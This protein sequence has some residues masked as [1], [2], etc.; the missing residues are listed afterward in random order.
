MWDEWDTPPQA[1]EYL[2]VQGSWTPKRRGFKPV[3]VAPKTGLESLFR[4][5]LI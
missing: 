1:E 5:Y 3:V 2:T 4:F